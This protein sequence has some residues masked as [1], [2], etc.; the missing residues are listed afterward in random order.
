[1]RRE[2]TALDLGR[3]RRGRRLG[4]NFAIL[5]ALARLQGGMDL[6]TVPSP[7]GGAERAADDWPGMPPPP[8]DVQGRMAE[9]AAD[10]RDLRAT[11]KLAVSL[12]WKNW[13]HPRE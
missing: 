12:T 8:N 5:S 13:L 3:V 10:D 7:D 6:W 4:L 9:P 2:K 11:L 1:V